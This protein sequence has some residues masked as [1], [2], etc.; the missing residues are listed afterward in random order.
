MKIIITLLAAA[1]RDVL[2]VFDGV[3][4]GALVSLNGVS[5][6]TLADQFLRYSFSVLP[7][8][9]KSPAVNTLIVTF[10]MGPGPDSQGRYVCLL[11]KINPAFLFSTFNYFILFLFFPLFSYLFCALTLFTLCQGSWPA[12]GA[13]IGH[14]IRTLSTSTGHKRSPRCLFPK[15]V[16]L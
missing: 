11:P 8:L 6:G 5:L 12:L 1:T 10:P 14:R 16:Y 9:K 13:G 4:M 15:R 3:K 2:L 7:I